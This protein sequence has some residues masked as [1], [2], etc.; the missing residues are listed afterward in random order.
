MNVNVRVS[1]ILAVD[2]SVE[3]Y[4]STRLMVQ[5][6]IWL[7]AVVIRPYN[8]NIRDLYLSNFCCLSFSIFSPC[9]EA[10]LLI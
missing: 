7:R 9:R 2:E 5:Q 4:V 6:V 8:S 1:G 3:K 10:L